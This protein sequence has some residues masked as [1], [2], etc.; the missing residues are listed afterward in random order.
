[1]FLITLLKSTFDG[2][3][4]VVMQHCMHCPDTSSVIRVITI[5]MNGNH[6]G[7]RI[8][9]K[10]ILGIKIDALVLKYTNVNI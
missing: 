8:V 4:V 3:I 2:R 6:I 7:N 5:S 10:T 1:M 9:Y